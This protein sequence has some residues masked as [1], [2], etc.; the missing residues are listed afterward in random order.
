MWE[1]RGGRSTSQSIQTSG[2]VDRGSIV[3]LV[4]QRDVVCRERG[5]IVEAQAGAVG[6]KGGEGG[7]E[8]V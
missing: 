1:S 5:N 7:E 2:S 6:G 4:V 8:G 3:E